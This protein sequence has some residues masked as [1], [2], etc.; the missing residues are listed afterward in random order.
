[1]KPN[2]FLVLVLLFPL[3]FLQAQLPEDFGKV[4]Q[5]E[6][7]L[8]VYDKD[9]DAAALVLYERGDNYFDVVQS[10]VRLVKEYRA[11]IKIL[12]KSGVDEG[13]IS[14]PL[15]HNGATKEE[16]PTIKAITHNG[17]QIINVLPSQMYTTDETE[18]WRV[19]TFTFPDIQV[20]SIL[21]YQYT[22]YSPYTFNFSGWNF[23]SNIPKLYSE[24]NAK[25]PA[26]YVYNRNLVGYLKLAVNEAKIVKECFHLDGIG[27]ADCEVLQYAMKDIP[28]FKEAEDFM[29]SKKNYISRLD[30]ELS[31]FQRLDGTKDKYTKSW[32]DVDREFKGDRDIGAQ[33]TKRNYFERNVPD[34]L[35]TGDDPVAKAKKIYTYVQQHYTWNGKYGIYKKIRVKE[36]FEEK[37][38]N[39]GEINIAMINLLNSAGIKTDLV[40]LSTRENGLPKTTR[41]VMSDFNYVI[42]RAEIGDSFY[43]LDATDKFLPFGML[44]YRCLNYLGRVMDFKKDSY[45]MDITATS[46]NRM[47][48]RG[49]MGLDP[50][51]ETIKGQLNVVTSGYKAL[52]KRKNIS[53]Y[54]KEEY[55]ENI[56]NQNNGNLEV[57]DY[58]NADLEHFEKMLREQLSFEK[59]A[60]M[61]ADKIY[62]NPLL[63]KFFDQNPFLLEERNYPIEFGYPRSYQYN[64]SISVPEGYQVTQFPQAVEEK[65][66]DNTA[67]LK[68]SASP[69][70]A[71]NIDVV[72]SLILGQ[73]FY[74][75][76]AYQDIK[77]LFAKVM[78]VQDHSLITLEK[79]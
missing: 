24:F 37:S 14:I 11:K 10:R 67:L 49:Q 60:S 44:P 34:S 56:I 45:W 6:R 2:R 50:E 35:F 48:I 4:S 77:K 40:L 66:P 28:A 63:I 57:T 7:E 36:A 52:Q 42:A 30:F 18:N 43:L 17:D 73:V 70:A 3:H 51:T 20:G 19:L 54:T 69:N 74:Q 31:E 8:T 23:Q 25:I 58:K 61:Q 33:L 75:P 62:L 22:L 12:K 78:E 71:G 26:N 76:E 39:V 55:A 27:N 15:Y 47:L 1:M 65:L 13:T 46:N 21:E 79:K 59:E 53:A 9:P 16:I 68:F 29:L 38:G 64:M 32:E 5:A 72:F 41:P